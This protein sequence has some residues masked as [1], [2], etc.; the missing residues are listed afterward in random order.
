MKVIALYSLGPEMSGTVFAVTR[1]A[2]VC[3]Y[4]PREKWAAAPSPQLVDHLR[5]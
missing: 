2:S 3:A 1:N 4:V 5:R